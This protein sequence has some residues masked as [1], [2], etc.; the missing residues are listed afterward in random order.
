[1]GP[2]SGG[3]AAG[4][5]HVVGGLSERTNGV[6]SHAVFPVP[7]GRCRLRPEGSRV[8]LASAPPLKNARGPIG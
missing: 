7:T 4:P 6:C 2:R 5:G 8:A 1:M 3:S